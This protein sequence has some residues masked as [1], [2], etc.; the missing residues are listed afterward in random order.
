MYESMF[1]KDLMNLQV[2]AKSAD[3]LFDFVG[4]DVQEKGFVNEGYIEVVKEREVN[5]PTGLVFP[6][7]E[8]AL[9]HVDPQYICKPFIYVVRNTQSLNW[10][11]MGDSKEMKACYFL[12]LG[13]K[14]PKKQVGLLS[15]I[16]A[17]FKDEIFITNFK[18]V[19]TPEEMIALLVNKFVQ[20]TV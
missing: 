11:Q 10:K 1:N 9:P 15:S 19:V 16:I 20:V 17:A 18:K 12:F 13:I 4:R 7:I 3:Q 5:Y 14:E 2:R 8:L 6:N